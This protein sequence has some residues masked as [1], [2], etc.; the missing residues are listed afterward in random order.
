MT[1]TA[2][3]LLSGALLLVISPALLAQIAPEKQALEAEAVRR[4]E[5][6]IV[7]RQLLTEAR[8]FH[9]KG[10][11]GNAMRVYGEALSLAQQIGEAGIEKERK[12]TI[13]GY[14]AAFLE[15][16]KR[17]YSQGNYAAAKNE[18]GQVLKV[19]PKNAA[20]QDLS[21][22]VEKA[23]AEQK[24]R[25]PS[26]EAAAYVLETEKER[27]AIGTLVQDGKLFYEMGKL[28]EA[29]AKLKEA[30]RRDPNNQG[31][32]YYLRLIEEARYAQDG[33]KRELMAKN[34][35]VEVES[36]WNPPIPP[37]K[38]QAANPFARTN[39]IHTGAGRT[40]IYGKMDKI[41]FGRFP[42][43]GDVTGL[44]LREVVKYLDDEVKAMDP[45]KKGVNFIISESI[46]KTTP[47]AGAGQ[48][49][50]STGQFIQAAPVEAF[51]VGATLITIQPVLKD[52]RLA[53]VLDAIIKV[54][55]KEIKFSVEEYAI[56]FS[57]KVPEQAELFTRTFRVNPN[58]FVQ[59]LEAVSAYPFGTGGTGGGGGGG[60]LGGG[61]GGGFGGG[62]G[63]LGGGAGGGQGIFVLPRVDVS[64]AGGGFGGGGG[65]GGGGG[66]GGGGGGFGGGGGGLGGGGGFGGGAL[67]GIT[68]T[69]VTSYYNDLVRA[70]FTAA[71]VNLGGS[72]V[73]AGGIAGGG[74]FGGAFQ[75]PQGKSV[76]FNDRL[77]LLMVRATMQD[78]DIIE[79]AI[80]VLNQTP[81]LIMVEAKFVEIGQDDTKALGFDWLLGNTMIDGGRLGGAGGTQ[82]SFVGAPTVANPSG[83]FPGT[84]GIPW[85][86]PQQ[87]DGNFT[88]GLRNTTA[89]G[90][91]IPA[92]G[93]FTGI[94]TD[95]QFRVVIRALEQRGGVDVLS[96]PKVTTVSGRQA[97]IQ[98]VDLQAIVVDTGVNQTGTGGI[99]GGGGGGGGTTVGFG[100]GGGVV[101]TAIV[102]TTQ[103]VPLGPTLDVIPYVSSDG[104]TVQMT[105]IPTL[106]E[107]LGYDDPGQ[108]S[109]LAQ[110]GAGGTV[111]S[112]LRAPVALPRLRVRQVTTSTIV[113]DGQT[114]LL[115][116]LIS[117]RVS[118]T[119]DKVPM[120][121]DL[122]LVGRLF[123]SEASASKK[124]NLV[125]FVTPTILDP[126]GNRVH[127]DDNLPYN[128][129]T[130]PPQTPVAATLP[131]PA[132]K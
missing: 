102:P 57:R 132:A 56:I 55:D 38:L 73:L 123:R 109:I 94:L 97:Q 84:F 104:Y 25:I 2:L 20:A 42:G 85:F 98:V 6:T 4:Q 86:A 128:P 72:N 108:F 77:G 129:N 65:G 71:G 91:S 74:A 90:T 21:K 7:L 30:V 14:A 126:A 22:K 44:P 60:G 75:G 118:K 36:A 63:G 35:M 120:L 33:R 130:I 121:G 12:E 19:S 64:G 93:T 68:R 131:A 76:F 58:T 9:K 28:Q 87:T 31:A 17:S 13:D 51:E 112:S 46:D 70:Y 45:E 48:V 82:P 49:D 62:G 54:A 67:S 117:E 23:L 18:V 110:G 40:A 16:A 50:P 105:L 99:G 92:L 81:D 26:D 88:Q 27:V 53:D 80:H 43:Q 107:F 95:P 47:S 100:G 29:E 78:L 116:G 103:Q 24:G 115:G 66:F 69:N 113:W 41:R 10:E 124:K 119:K 11:L 106:T 8:Q 3:T 125:I 83:V 111:G 39:T 114:V 15:Q 59:G 89:E 127:T 37:G 5:N 32:F 1:R 52:V 122:P 96:A 101:G 79:A 34:K 61:G